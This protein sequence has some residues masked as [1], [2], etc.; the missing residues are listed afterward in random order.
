MNAARALRTA[1]RRA[2]LSQTELARLAGVA[3]QAVNRIER[4]EIVP[5]TDTLERLLAAAGATLSIAPLLGS[6]IARGP[7]RELLELPPRQ[8]L[9]P[10][11]L[12]ALDTLRNR[13]VHFIVVGDA[14]AR[15]HGTPLD[16]AEVEIALDPDQLNLGKFSRALG[17]SEVRKL[18]R[19]TGSYWQF[20]GEAQELPWLP[21]P[22]M[23]VLN[24]WLDAPQGFVASL[25]DLARNATPMRR[26][27]IAAVQEEIDGLGRGHR[28]HRRSDWA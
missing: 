1:R 2:G 7:I 26:E 17:S 5:R 10:R 13:R 14:A 18:I 8:R 27:L 9:S 4:A 15:L 19:H 11:Q 23:R 24:R 6:F 20:R 25:D 3:R 16:V 21:A 12:A 28:I 22:R